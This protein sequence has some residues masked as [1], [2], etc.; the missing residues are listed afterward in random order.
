MNDNG[1]LSFFYLNGFS[2][3]ENFKLN[4]TLQK[5]AQQFKAVAAGGIMGY[6]KARNTF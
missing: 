4:I 6:L 5:F 1:K 3:T 2:G